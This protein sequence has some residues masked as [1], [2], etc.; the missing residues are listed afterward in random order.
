METK[1]NIAELLK[2]CPK[3]TKLYSP[4]FGDVY[5]KKLDHI[6]PLLLLL[7]KD[8]VILTKS[9]YMMGDIE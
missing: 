9:F 6:L 5:L 7:I 3:G 8:K 2:D 1:I 4:I